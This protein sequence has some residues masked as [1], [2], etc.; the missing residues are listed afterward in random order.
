MALGERKKIEWRREKGRK[1][2]ERRGKVRG[3]REKKKMR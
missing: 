2:K 1:K 3:G